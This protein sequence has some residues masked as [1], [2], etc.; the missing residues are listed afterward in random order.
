M[1]KNIFSCLNSKKLYSKDMKILYALELLGYI[2]SVDFEKNNAEEFLLEKGLNIK[3]KTT[4]IFFR[5][6]FKTATKSGRICFELLAENGFFDSINENKKIPELLIF[7]G[8]TQPIFDYNE[9]IFEKVYVEVPLD[10]DEDGKRDLVEVYIHRPKETLWGMKVPVIYVANPYMK[11]CNDEVYEETHPVDKNLKVYESQNIKCEE[12]LFVPKHISIPPERETNKIVDLSFAKETNLEAISEWYKYFNSRGFASVFSAG[13]GTKGSQGINCTGSHE[14]KICAIAIIEWLTGKRKAYTNLKDNIEIKATWCNCKVAMTGKSY[15]GTLAIAAATT[16]VEGLKTIIPEAAISNWYDYYRMNG[17]VSAPL[18]WQGDDSNLL[19]E[20]CRT[21]EIPTNNQKLKL[22]YE[23][24]SQYMLEN[25]D[26]DSGNYNS[27]WDERNYLKDIKHI[28]CSVFLIQGLNDWNVKTTHSIKLWKYLK[29]YNIPSKMLLHQ[30]DHIYIHGLKGSDFFNMMNL[31]LSHWLLDIDNNVQEQFPDLMIQSNLDSSIWANNYLW[32]ARKSINTTVKI[33]NNK[34]TS[35]LIPGNN[36]EILKIFEDDIDNTGFN[37]EKNN[38]KDWRNNIILLPELEKTYRI[39]YTTEKLLKDLHINGNINIEFECACDQ[40]T[41]ILSAMLVDLGSS[42]RLLSTQNIISK[43][44]ISLGKN[45]TPIDE[46]DFAFEEKPSLYKIITRGH[47]NIQNRK[48]IYS[49]ENI[50]KNKFYK[51][52]FQLVP[53]D[54]TIKKGNQLQL[55]IYG[56]DVEI[57]QRPF[58]KTKF[59]IKENTIT[60]TFNIL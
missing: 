40:P 44:K 47:L 1:S 52:S 37:R 43:N 29:K 26:R 6:V 18:H 17:L 11:P 51:Y 21:R 28:N 22:L 12:T 31:W 60:L 24:T 59:T 4:E 53:T 5:E 34:L 23:K 42:C 56:T 57:T 39:S 16:G 8:K 55:I 58:I 54:Y 50:E 2:E 10:T 41:G 36:D 20:Y 27:Y 32:P 13:L 45:I 33:L 30:G 19:T 7:D 35:D 48:N 25:Q 38:Y 15:L 49:K 14:E 3:G 46:W 9:F